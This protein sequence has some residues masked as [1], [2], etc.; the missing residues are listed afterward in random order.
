MGASGHL[1]A[2]D[3]GRHRLFVATAPDERG[4]PVEPEHRGIVHRWR[5]EHAVRFTDRLVD[6]AGAAQER[7]IDTVTDA[8]GLV[9]ARLSDRCAD[10]TLR[11]AIPAA[12][13]PLCRQAVVE[14]FA[15]AG[16]A[17]EHAALVERPVAAAAGWLAHRV[18]TSGRI[19]DEPTLVIDNDG[20]QLS[21]AA[22]DPRTKRILFARPLSTGPDDDPTA[23]I[24]RL[25]DAVET[26]AKLTHDGGLIRHTDWNTVSASVGDV[27]VTGSGAKNPDFQRLI[28]AVLPSAHA[29]PD[30]IVA[31]DRAVVTGLAHLHHFDD[32]K[33]CWPT[34]PLDVGDQDRNL[35]RFGPGGSVP[36][37]AGTST[38]IGIR[39]PSD[40][41]G[42][43]ELRTLDDGR[44]LF[45]GEQGTR[46]L[47]L[48]V[49]WPCPGRPPTSISIRSLG[50]RALELVEEP[51]DRVEPHS[52][53]RLTT[54]SH[55]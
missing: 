39:L 15:T 5:D 53:S 47:A 22:L 2:V 37:R 13:G 41:A 23:V 9:R 46:P 38:G 24:E 43:A 12:F 19:P 44:L 36:L 55:N 8:A 1:V 27:V 49:D 51:L 4:A 14:G 26:T 33:A 6:F 35:V 25:R 50:R 7:A 3:L 20:G 31:S 52:Q 29:M 30:P 21:I 28:A 48:G 11:V 34:T 17:V 32:W 16:L 42:S 10:P 54:S 45:I 40:L 18:E